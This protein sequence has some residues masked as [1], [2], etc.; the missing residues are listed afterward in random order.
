M[1]YHWKLSEDKDNIAWLS[2]DKADSTT[3][4]LSRD[5]IEELDGMLSSVEA[6]SPAGLILHSAKKSGFCA[7]ADVD[8]FTKI[9]TREEAYELIRR[10]Q[11]IF[12]RLENM[13]CP[14]L[15]LIHG[16]CLGGGMELA[17]ACDYRIA[18]DDDKTRMGLPEVKLGIHPGFAGSV[19][20][21]QL[22]G[23]PAAMSL[24]LAGRTF[25]GRTAKKL[26]VVSLSISERLIES[27]ARQFILKPPV[28][29]RARGL[30]ALTNTVLLRPL[31]GKVFRSSLKKKIRQ[32]HYPAPFAQVGI[33]EKYGGNP[34]AMT[35]AEADSVADLVITPTAQNLIRLFFLQNRLKGLA[36]DS[37]FNAKH[38]HVIGAGVMGGDIAAWCAL[39]GM[40]VT[41]QDREASAIAPAIKRAHALFKKH[42]K[43]PRE[44]QHAHDRLIP[45]LR[46]DGI[47]GADVII[48]AIFENLEVKQKLLTDVEKIARPDA[49]LASNTSSLRIEAIARTL[50]SPSRLVGIHFFNPVAKMM[51]VEIVQGKQ[52]DPETVTMAAAFTKQIGKLPLPVKS[53]PGFL[54]NRILM[55]YLLESVRALE[56]GIPGPVID[57]AARDFGMPMGPIEL[58]DTV[59]LDICLHVANILASDLGTEVPAILTDKVNQGL[60]GEK[61]GEGF[62]RYSKGRKTVQSVKSRQI[63]D[64]LADRLILR[65]IN[66]AVQCLH[67]KV[68]DDPDLMD[69]GVVFGTGF[70]PFHGGPMQYT[71]SRGVEKVQKR[72]QELQQTYGD[73][74]KLSEGW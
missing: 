58:A 39:R 22:I 33:W 55:P 47:K 50:Q 27:A 37:N 14:T 70:A 36:K 30:K 5:V 71:A 40:K 26:G 74:F 21:T 52:S 23:A 65:L 42:L 53:S 9:K 63:P 72:L 18:Q 11:T 1:A 60:L 32:D 38:V 17:L 3:N 49:V 12:D 64:D 46:G 28:K 8:E 6:L 31:L 20:M 45:D 61:T 25:D 68:V 66:E 34:S 69:A 19:R 24:I 56:D 7:G 54:V 67:E 10:A 44:I 2:F 48:E 73:R 4:V 35:L 16:F 43:K 29:P 13:S 41:L 57:K 62:Y 15:C 51:L 59:G